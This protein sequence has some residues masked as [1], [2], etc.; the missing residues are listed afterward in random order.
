MPGFL[1][2][3]L[4]T[5]RKQRDLTQAELAHLLSITDSGLSRF[6][7]RSRRPTIDL[8]LGSEV[9][10]GNPAREIFPFLYGGVEDRV[11]AQAKTLFARLECRTDLSAR[12]KLNFLREMIARAEAHDP[13]L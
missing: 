7:T 13:T 1:P 2:I 3:Y 4:A 6:E 12:E 10:F 9:I 5:L 8:V 11:M